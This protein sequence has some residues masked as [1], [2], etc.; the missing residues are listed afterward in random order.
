[1]VISPK[2]YFLLYFLTDVLNELNAVKLT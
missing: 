1:M 2:F